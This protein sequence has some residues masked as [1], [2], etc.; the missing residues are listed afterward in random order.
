MRD[1]HHLS[2]YRIR[3]GPL[4]SDDTAGKYGMFK[5]PLGPRRCAVVIA[6]DA[7]ETG[8]EHVSVHIRYQNKRRSTILRTPTWDEMCQI[9]DHFWG[10]EEAVAQYHPP[11]AEYVNNHPHTL[12]LWKPARQALPRPPAILV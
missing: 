8:W 11:A 6:A 9:K 10:P 5:I 1:L 3:K 12:H 2:R 7:H 4:G